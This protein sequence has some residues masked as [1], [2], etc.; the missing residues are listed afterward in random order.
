MVKY[1]GLGRIQGC[2][3]PHKQDRQG[4]LVSV[5]VEVP[6]LCKYVFHFIW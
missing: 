6:I 1:K 3:H 5:A 4:G 2:V